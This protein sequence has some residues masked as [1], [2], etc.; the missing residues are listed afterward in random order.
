VTVGKATLPVLRI[1]DRVRTR[2]P[3]L[4]RGRSWI[5]TRVACGSVSRPRPPNWPAWGSRRSVSG[6]SGASGCATRRRALPGW[7]TGGLTASGPFAA[8]LT[9]GWWRRCTRRSK[10]PQRS[11]R[12]PRATFYWRVA[13]LLTA[14]H[15]AGVVAMPSRATFYRL[16]DRL[17][18][19]RHTTGSAR[20]R[21][22]LANRPDGPF[23]ELTA[24]RPGELVQIDSTKL[25]VLVL[26]EEGVPGRVELTGTVDLATRSIPAAVLRPSTKS[27][28]AS[29]LP[30]RTVTPELMRPGWVDAL[31]MSRSVLPHRRLLALDQ[32]LE[33]AAARPVIVPETIVC[34][35][36]KA[37]L[38]H[39]FRSACSRRGVRR[40]HADRLLAPLLGGRRPAGDLLDAVSLRLAVGAG[41]HGATGGNDSARRSWTS[42]RDWRE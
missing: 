11:R 40:R 26:L 22:S 7:S 12:G 23:G 39:N 36:G 24:C 2:R 30:A 38:S 32:R 4:G 16:F 6:P 15:G 31:R 13:Q 34:D 27:V 17:S 14:Q 42:W 20:T 19:G 41:P 10:R 33:H 18:Q 25:D 35:H 28:D 5:L 9:L 1:G 29:V 8:E 37:F 21:R 3:T